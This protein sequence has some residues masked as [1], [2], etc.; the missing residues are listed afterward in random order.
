MEFSRK[1]A[2]KGR[3]KWWWWICDGGMLEVKLSLEEDGI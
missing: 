1:K 2:Q 3:K